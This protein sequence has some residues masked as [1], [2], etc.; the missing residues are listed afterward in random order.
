MSE[1]D[2]K[3]VADRLRELLEGP[4]RTAVDRIASSVFFSGVGKA[5]A[6]PELADIDDADLHRALLDLSGRILAPI[7]EKTPAT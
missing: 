7:T 3:A 1:P 6:D 2:F 5:A 4:D